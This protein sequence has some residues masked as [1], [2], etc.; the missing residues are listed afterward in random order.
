MDEDRGEPHPPV[1]RGYKEPQ[2]LFSVVDTKKSDA[3]MRVID[4]ANSRW[5]RR[6]VGC[7]VAAGDDEAERRMKREKLSPSWTTSWDDVPKVTV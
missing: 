2:A 1:Q 4:A 7:G 3:L 5:G 6:A